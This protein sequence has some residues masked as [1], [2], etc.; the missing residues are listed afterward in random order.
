MKVED[1]FGGP[2]VEAKYSISPVLACQIKDS[3]LAAAEDIH[4]T[5]LYC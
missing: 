3:R 4:F 5:K 2:V 1:G